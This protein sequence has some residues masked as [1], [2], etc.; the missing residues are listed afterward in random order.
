VPG[1]AV[2]GSATVFVNAMGVIPNVVAAIVNGLQLSGAAFVL[3]APLGEVGG[4]AA[5]C[6]LGGSADRQGSFP[7]NLMITMTQC[8]VPTSDGS[9][10]FDGV[11]SVQLTSFTLDIDMRFAD[12][13]GNPTLSATAQMS[14]SLVPVQGGTCFLTAATLTI[15][16]GSVSATTASGDTVA[17]TFQGTRVVLDQITFDANCV[18]EVYRLTFDGPVV[19]QAP[20]GDPLEVTLTALIMA[21]D[22][23]GAST[24]IDL[25]GEVDSA[26]FGG[27]ASIATRASITVRSDEVCPT[28]GE[29]SATL[30]GSETRIY[31]RTDQSVDIDRGADGS[32][33]VSA[34]NCLDPRLLAC[35]G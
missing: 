21:V 5:A 4:P 23:S 3:P 1:Q 6:P 34:P 28:A 15:S 14:G 20:N 24:L 19:L 18:P 22:G 16:S 29:V 30:A 33:D 7:F 27:S 26:C 9:T 11:I 25:T 32:I 13:A 35:L 8:R 10:T 17:A 31:Y 2:A 12:P